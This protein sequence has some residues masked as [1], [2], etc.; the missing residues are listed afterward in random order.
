MTADDELQEM[1]DKALGLLFRRERVRHRK[2]LNEEV[3]WGGDIWRGSCISIFLTRK[4][5]AGSQEI[6][7]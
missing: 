2:V 6:R 5:I 4:C 1:Y 3:S 7:R